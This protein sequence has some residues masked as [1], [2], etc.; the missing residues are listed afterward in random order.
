MYRRCQEEG[1]EVCAYFVTDHRALRMYGLG[2]VKPRPVPYK[3]HIRNGYL[4]RG[5]TLSDLAKQIG[6]DAKGLE[7]TVA[8]YNRHAA[9]GEDPEFGKGSNA[10]HRSLG[11]PEHKPNPC[12]APVEKGPFYAV[13]LVIGD[14]GTF[15][16]LSCNGNAQVLDEAKRPIMGLYAAGNDALSVMGGNYPGGGI[17]LGPAVTFG[18]L[19]ARHMAGVNS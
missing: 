9:H 7:T 13:K 4:F 19:A 12:L 15:A 10:Y 14:L 17:T 2:F 3:T 11:D 16:G 18:Y 6:V 8:A 5:R 1:G